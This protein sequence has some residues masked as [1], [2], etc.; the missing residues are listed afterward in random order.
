[1]SNPQLIRHEYPEGSKAGQALLGY[2]L[3]VQQ[4]LPTRLKHLYSWNLN[5]WSIPEH[6]LRDP[7]T[8]RCRRRLRTGPLCLQD[9][10]WDQGLPEKL[11]GF[12][13]G[14]KIFSTPAIPLDSGKRSG[15][16]QSSFRLGGKLR[17]FMS[18]FPL[19]HLQYLYEIGS[20]VFTSC[21]STCT[22]LPKS[23]TWRNS[24]RNGRDLRKTPQEP[25]L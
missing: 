3:T 1:M 25:S 9:T 11:A 17:R 2:R 15:G 6:P 4:D 10:K 5:S 23:V 18:L 7:K 21:Q 8:R 19:K 14:T 16:C 24:C 13:P 20:R 22:L 12:L